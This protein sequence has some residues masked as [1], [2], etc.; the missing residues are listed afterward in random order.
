[1]VLQQGKVVCWTLVLFS[2][3]ALTASSS[4][5][6]LVINEIMPANSTTLLDE[7]EEFSAKCSVLFEARAEKYLDAECIAMIGWQ[8]FSHL[9]KAIK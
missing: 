5:Q 2:W 3:Y 1:M 9:K 7:D 4:A 6:G 8:L